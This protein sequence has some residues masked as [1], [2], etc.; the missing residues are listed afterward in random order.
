LGAKTIFT[1][2]A[3]GYQNRK[4]LGRCPDCSEWQSFVEEVEQPAP[5]KIKQGAFGAITASRPQKLSEVEGSE[6]SRGSSGSQEFDRVLGGGMVKG[7]LVLL[8][9]DPGIGKSTL[10]LQ[11]TNACAQNGM[12][13][14]YVT[15]EESP[16]QTKL[17]FDRIGANAEELW[18]V[19]DTSVER[20]EAHIDD[21]KPELLVIDS[22]Q[23]LFTTSLSSSPGSV[24]QLRAATSRMMAIA[25]GKEVTTFLVGHVTKDG[26]IAGPRVLEHMVDTVLQFEG[27]KG[28]PLRLLRAIKNRFGSTDEIGTFEMVES[29]MQEVT[30]PSEQFLSER[31]K[32]ASGSVVSCSYEGT[33]PLLVEVQALVAPT[34]YG[35]PRRTTLGVDSNRV[36]MLLAILEKKA[37]LDVAGADVFLNVAGGLRLD[38]PAVDLGVLI[39]LASSHIDRVVDQETMIFGEVGLSGEVRAVN[40]APSRIA[41]ARQLG[42]RKVVMPKSNLKHLEKRED[43]EGM[44]LIGVSHIVEA[45]D[46]VFD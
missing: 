42:F 31:A 32:D 16:R 35:N 24:S 5:S 1:C 7:S 41:E 39:S 26:A 44:M 15:G 45:L 6:V 30:N 4:W 20:I 38:E 8:G 40:G 43:D 11:T 34:V 17:R 36:A 23:T 21:I 9:G 10:L 29:G 33:R 3:C 27:Q 19:A 12:R 28:H 18:I 13:V 14:L 46:A 2:Q 22:I 37:G 25:K